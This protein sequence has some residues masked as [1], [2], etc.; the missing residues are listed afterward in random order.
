MLYAVVHLTVFFTSPLAAQDVVARVTIDSSVA[1]I[2]QP[3][4]LVLQLSQPKNISVNWPLFIDSL[5]GIEIWKYDQVDTMEVEDESLL[6]RS[7]TLYL[8]SYDSGVFIVPPIEFKYPANNGKGELVASTDPIQI[9]FNTVPVDTT[10]DIRDIRNVEAA[11][12]DYR[13]ILYGVIAFH[14]LLLIVALLVWAFQKKKVSQQTIESVKLK[15][16]PH[17][18]ALEALVLLEEERV[19]QAGRIKEYYTRLTEILRVYVE[20]RWGFGTLELTSDEILSHAAISS[21][22]AGIREDL[23]RVLRLSDLVKF[24]RW[25]AIPS[26]NEWAMQLAQKFVRNTAVLTEP[27]NQVPEIKEV[28]Q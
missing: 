23:E 27:E 5:G 13:I 12:F 10:Q 9:T 20:R 15:V 1:L 14:L 26:E 19:W 22:D 3:V 25:Q 28:E 4:R 18:E 8:T 16:S 2:G 24:A 7:Q 17:I 6:L 11:P 21:L